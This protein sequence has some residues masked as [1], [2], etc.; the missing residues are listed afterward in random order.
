MILKGFMFMKNPILLTLIFFFISSP[1]FADS[2]YDRQNTTMLYHYDTQKYPPVEPR[3]NVVRAYCIFALKSR[4]FSEITQADIDQANQLIIDTQTW[5]VDEGVGGSYW[6]LPHLAMIACSPRLNQY[7]STGGEEAI[8]AMLYDYTKEHAVLTDIY[9]VN[10]DTIWMLNSSD[11]HN[12]VRKTIVYCA[13]LLFKDD[14]QYADM[15]IDDGSTFQQH[16]DAF[17]EYFPKFFQQRAISGI[18]VEFNS[19]PYSGLYL[20]A[21]L[22]IRECTDSPAVHTIISKYL[23]VLFTETAMESLNGIRGGA[24]IRSYKDGSSYNYKSH[25][26]TYYNWLFSGLPDDGGTFTI[27]NSP[28]D[29]IPACITDYRLPQEALNLYTQPQSRGDFEY[30]SARFGRGYWEHPEGG[31][32]MQFL[33]LPSS[34]RRYT[35]V[36]PLF[37]LGTFTLDETWETYVGVRQNHWMGVLGADNYSSR[38]YVQAEPRGEDLRTGYND[39]QAVQKNGTALIR[40]NINISQNNQYSE[41]RRL[42]LFF[43]EDFGYNYD[44]PTGWLFSQNSDGSVYLAAAAVHKT[45]PAGYSFVYDS[46]AVGDFI[47]VDNLDAVIILDVRKA[48]DYADFQSFQ[49]DILD[50]SVSWSSSGD[51]LTYTGSCG[52]TLTMYADSRLPKVNSGQ[53]EINPPQ[54]YI[55]PYLQVGS[56]NNVIIS[57]QYGG[58]TTLNFDYCVE[59]LPADIDR[60]CYVGLG[61]FAALAAQWLGCTDPDNIECGD[62]ILN[63]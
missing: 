18:Q 47:T 32:Y 20:M 26:L 40:R 3:G 35:Y 46:Q 55:S 1:I 24:A 29:L 51:A 33:Q 5:P 21:S 49:N 53:V 10:D 30:I 39:L 4:G 16:Y 23:D 43:S 15:P 59:Y 57:D 28:F 8:K 42:Q 34:V 37:T 63:P 48:A 52:D 13:S 6:E 58:S 38:V 2:V 7:L 14:P 44:P 9:P 36:T 62:F 22:T 45:D 11:N 25:K 12:L 56:G 31:R 17:S 60:S 27:G 41:P 54:I 19:P 61:D 50:N